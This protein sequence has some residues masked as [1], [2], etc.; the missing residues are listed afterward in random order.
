MVNDIAMLRKFCEDQIV[1]K[2]MERKGNK[3]AREKEAMGAMGPE[4]QPSSLAPNQRK[5]ILW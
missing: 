2:A 4:A 1:Q 5:R 3:K